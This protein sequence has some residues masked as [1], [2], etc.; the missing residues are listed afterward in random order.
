MTWVC[1]SGVADTAPAE[2]IS[3]PAPPSPPSTLS[4]NLH[5]VQ[6]SKHRLKEL[7]QGTESMRPH[8]TDPSKLIITYHVIVDGKPYR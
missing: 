5:P 4:A 7:R 8:P 3:A 6:A 1:C 2:L